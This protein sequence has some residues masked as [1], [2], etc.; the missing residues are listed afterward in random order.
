MKWVRGSNTQGFLCFCGLVT[1]GWASRKKAQCQPSVAA[2]PVVSA[3]QQMAEMRPLFSPS[4]PL[5]VHPSS[6]LEELGAGCPV[7]PQHGC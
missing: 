4:T 5:T 1:A 6:C 7:S 2:V 3:T